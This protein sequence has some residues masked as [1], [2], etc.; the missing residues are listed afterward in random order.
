ML[1][2]DKH[3]PKTLA[4]LTHHPNTTER[5]E[6]LASN[7]AALPHLLFHGPP[8]SGRRTRIHALLRAIYGPG[9]D[10]L[11]LD[12]RTFTTPTKKTVEIHT[13]CSNYHIEMCPGDVGISD[14]YVVQDVIKEMA[15]NRSL[16]SVSTDFSNNMFDNGGT[17]DTSVSGKIPKA[18]RAE[19]KIVVLTEVDSLSK[20]AQAALRRT[21]EQYA[22]GC[23]L[24]LCCTHHSKVID[25]LRSRCLSFRIPAPSVD[26]ICV[27][28]KRVAKKERVTL[29]DELCINLARESDRNMRRA[30]LSL[31]STL[32]ASGSTA[33]RTLKPDETVRK[34]DWEMYIIQLA[35][36]ITREQS[37]QRL[38]AAR[39]KIYEL[40]INCIPPSVILK[41]LV[42]ELM[43]S[44]D[45]AL[46]HDVAEAAAF[47]E[48]RIAMGSRDIFHLEAFVAK[49]MALYKK[50]LNDMFG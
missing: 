21:M 36:D 18:T 20:Q 45:D 1:W 6:S 30:L 15:A 49:F 24:I 2:V 38:I 23:R 41:T 25:P 44:L 29:P 14:R 22:A 32:V 17:D 42:L 50:Y 13:V 12:R 43:K 39:E 19:Y 8:G 10:R 11:R 46:K 35:S 27:G 5:L 47:Y 34:T 9:A 7:P 33:S 48:H 28:L 3:R 37:P 31:E 26:D 16:S 4:A 40:L